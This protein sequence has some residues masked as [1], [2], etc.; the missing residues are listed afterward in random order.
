MDINL[1]IYIERE[2][3]RDFYTSYIHIFINYININVFLIL[4]TILRRK[5]GQVNNICCPFKDSP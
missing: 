5:R 3:E 2:R 1:N 4:Y